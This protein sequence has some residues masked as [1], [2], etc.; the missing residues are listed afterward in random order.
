LIWKTWFRVSTSSKEFR[1]NFPKK[2]SPIFKSS[3][4]RE[5]KLKSVWPNI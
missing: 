2:N 1:P 5:N 3:G 4:T